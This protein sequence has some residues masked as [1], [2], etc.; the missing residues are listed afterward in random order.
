MSGLHML[1]AQNGWAWTDSG[2]LLRTSDGGQS[3]IDRSAGSG[4]E[5]LAGF[6]LDSQTAWQPINFQT[7]NQIGLLQTVDGGQTWRL[8][9]YGPPN[10]P[11]PDL[12]VHFNDA[13]N[14]WAESAGVGAGNI[15]FILF[16]TPDG[17]K[18]WATIPA[19]GP[20][21]ETGLPPGMIHLCNICEDSLYYDPQRLLIVHGD[22]GSMQSSGA[23]RLEVSFDLGNTWQSQ[24]LPLP[25][26]AA[27]AIVGHS[28]ATF[29]SGGKG[30]LSVTLVKMD[31][32]GNIMDQSLAFYVT[33]DGGASWSL[34]P[35][36]LDQVGTFPLVQVVSPDDIFAVCGAS[37]CASQDGSQTWQKLAA[38]LDLSQS[39]SRTILALDLVDAKTGWVL[40]KQN[41]ASQLYQTT[42]GG[43]GWK[44]LNPLLAAATP[45]TVDLTSLPTPTPLP[46]DTPEASPT[47]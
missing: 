47:P 39:D 13:L 9:S 29:F 21:A 41:D 45:V 34:A 36:G 1:D 46:S 20:T 25:A 2:Q 7:N 14:G 33:Q 35:G 43:M 32:S 22:E 10:A 17:G 4:S 18:T 28:A 12:A 42:D 11:G 6:Y 31:A 23:V 38:N 8:I 24:N 16:S 19:K 15:Y 27:N 5:P 44:Q 40:I 3:W 37:L 30:I 26:N